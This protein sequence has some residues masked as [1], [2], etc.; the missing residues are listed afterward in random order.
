MR[1]K[2]ISCGECNPEKWTRHQLV[3]MVRVYP[4]RSE[5]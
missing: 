1:R 5:D 2:L 3:Y 4:M